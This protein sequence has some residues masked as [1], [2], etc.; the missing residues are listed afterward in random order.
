MYLA[1]WTDPCAPRQGPSRT[2]DHGAL[3]RFK[4]RFLWLL[5]VPGIGLLTGDPGVGK[6]AMLRHL[7]LALNPHRHQVIYLADTDFSRTDLYRGLAL[8]LGA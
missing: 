1:L 6:T 3:T 8:A 5:E 4:E 7:T 2:L